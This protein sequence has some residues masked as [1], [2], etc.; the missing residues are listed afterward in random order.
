[1]LLTRSFGRLGRRH[2]PREPVDSTLPGLAAARS[3]KPSATISYACSLLPLL[4][5]IDRTRSWWRSERFLA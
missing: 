3:R 2:E 4:P 5:R 1:M